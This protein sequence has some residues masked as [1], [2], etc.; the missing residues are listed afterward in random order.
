MKNALFEQ[1]AEFEESTVSNP[2]DDGNLS[3]PE[4]L[5]VTDPETAERVE[6][7]VDS[8]RETLLDPE[9]KPD[10]QAIAELR[11][12]GVKVFEAGD[13]QDGNVSAVVIHTAHG[14]ICVEANPH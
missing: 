3:G 6:T 1:L 12:S 11:G 10:R 14:R 8:M 9:G 13:P 5:D 7:I 4:F 2:D